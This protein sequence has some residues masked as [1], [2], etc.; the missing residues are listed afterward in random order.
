MFHISLWM[1]GEL[2]THG[3]VHGHGAVLGVPCVSCSERE[4]LMQMY[5]MYT[6]C[7][8]SSTSSRTP[9]WCFLFLL[10]L[11]FVSVRLEAPPCPGISSSPSCWPWPFLAPGK[12]SCTG[13][14]DNCRLFLL[15]CL[16][17]SPRIASAGSAHLSLDDTFKEW[18]VL[19]EDSTWCLLLFPC[20]YVCDLLIVT[21]LPFLVIIS[22]MLILLTPERF[23]SSICLPFGNRM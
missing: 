2:S 6:S 16:V 9:C 1:N 4:T 15:P 19:L 13:K 7:S 23:F 14:G 22:L 11:F 20:S 5:T 12:W 17:T 3:H 10:F 8:P 21:L 18:W